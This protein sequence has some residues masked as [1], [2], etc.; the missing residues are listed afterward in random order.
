MQP[1]Y[2]HFPAM[3]SKGPG[4]PKK[5]K[6]KRSGRNKNVT[7][8]KVVVR[9]LP[10][11]LP[12]EL[13]KE[14]VKKWANEETTDWFRFH[15]GRISKRYC[16][17]QKPQRL[18]IG[19]RLC[20]VDMFTLLF[21]TEIPQICLLLINSKNK[22]AIFSRAYFHF[23]IMEDVLEFHRSYDNH[24]FIDNRGWFINF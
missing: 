17:P 6:A 18:K 22:E 11:N 2:F 14:S 12:E 24:L 23:K 4:R 13:F 1:D 10:P 16:F 5:S 8:T 3:S 9:R 19:F 7:K 15:K 21:V 20:Y